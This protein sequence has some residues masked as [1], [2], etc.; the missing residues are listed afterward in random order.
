MA[1]IQTPYQSIESQLLEQ[2][3]HLRLL[4]FDV[5]G[6]FSDGRI[7]LGNNGEE[8]KSFHTLDG[9]GIKSLLKQGL[10]VAVITGR[11]SGLVQQRMQSLGVEHIIQGEEN[12]GAA[13]RELI[14]NLDLQP[15]QVA[16]MGD[17]MPDLPMFELSGL[18]FS[19][20]GAHPLVQQ[21]ADYITLRQGGYGAVREICDLVLQALG[22]L[23]QIQGSS[24]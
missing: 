10:V 3:R 16:S 8:L 20:P 1:V 7:Y 9:Y 11:R 15:E 22:Q 19:V 23:H 2:C 17:D 24:V 21:Q 5:D 12:K 18:S 4:A 6:I 13:L 14:T